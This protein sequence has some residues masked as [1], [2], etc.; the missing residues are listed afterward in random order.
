MAAILIIG[1]AEGLI[2]KLTSSLLIDESHWV[3]ICIGTT[4][5]FAALF[6]SQQSS[7]VM[8]AVWCLIIFLRAFYRTKK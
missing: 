2:E 6:T 7:Q 1:R 5:D 3:P 8:T 4:F